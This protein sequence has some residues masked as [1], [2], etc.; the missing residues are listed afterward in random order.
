MKRLALNTRGLLPAGL[1]LACG[2]A[3]GLAGIFPRPVAV[4]WSVPL[5]EKDHFVPA[6]RQDS[7]DEIVFVFIGS[8][9]CRWS[10]DPALP[11]LINEARVAV[12][13]Q[14]L[15]MAAG[16]ASIGLTSDVLAEKGLEHLRRFGR[17]DEVGSGMGWHNAGLR[18][19][20]HG[21]LPG[22]ALT[23]QVLIVSRSIM[24]HA[25]S[26]TIRNERVLVR[27]LGLSSIRQ[28][29]ES[30]ARVSDSGM[31]RP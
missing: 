22:P 16:F 30:G 3:A 28:W 24:V 19:Y 10:N 21:D 13:D 14:S 26:R 5:F 6:V 12:R 29:V 15:E 7:G 31:E 18:K 9:G 25:G 20:V 2:I 27:L 8:S 23:P 11:A 4:R 17:F 1:A